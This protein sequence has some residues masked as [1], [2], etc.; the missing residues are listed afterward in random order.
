[1]TDPPP[2]VML[3]LSNPSTSLSSTS[4]VAVTRGSDIAEFSL[5]VS[6]YVVGGAKTV[7]VEVKE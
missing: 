5:P 2:S 6:G 4:P 3:I 1:L 7:Q